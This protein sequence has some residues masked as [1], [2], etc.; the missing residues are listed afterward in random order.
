MILLVLLFW[1][2]LSVFHYPK[3][4]DKSEMQAKFSTVHRTERHAVMEMRC[5]YFL[6][7]I[8]S[9]CC[10]KGCVCVCATESLTTS[11]FWKL[12]FDLVF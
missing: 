7:H 11:T 3:C 4:Y 12:Y 2:Y 1:G 8:F 5:V 9:F 10:E 6:G